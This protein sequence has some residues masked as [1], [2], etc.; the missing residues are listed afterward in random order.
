M[1]LSLPR[2][3]GASCLTPRWKRLVPAFLFLLTYIEPHG[4]RVSF[5]EFKF[6]TLRSSSEFNFN[7]PP[8][9]TRLPWPAWRQR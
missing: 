3:G 9:I 4:I 2:S 1:P 7:L 6:G 5:I 8:S